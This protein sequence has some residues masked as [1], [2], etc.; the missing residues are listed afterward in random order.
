MTA[1]VEVTAGVWLGRHQPADRCHATGSRRRSADR[2][3]ALRALAGALAALPPGFAE[4][5]AVSLS[6]SE[7]VGVAL[8][9]ACGRR[10]GVDVVRIARV[11]ERHARAILTTRERARLRG[12]EHFPPAAAWALKEAA[13]K[14]TGAPASHFPDRLLIRSADPR[15]S[16]VQVL[17]PRRRELVGGWSARAGFLCAWLIGPPRA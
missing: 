2:R 5:L 1:A 4:D 15:A 13:A 9:A 7:G 17:G 6:H 10:I 3:G 12:D 8:V 16:V 11:G 14:A